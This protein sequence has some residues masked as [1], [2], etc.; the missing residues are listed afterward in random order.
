MFCYIHVLHYLL[1]YAITV[2]HLGE[3][4]RE[5]GGRLHSADICSRLHTVTAAD[6]GR[7][8]LH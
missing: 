6:T 8:S 4:A 1:C 5:F 3:L 2:L 7:I